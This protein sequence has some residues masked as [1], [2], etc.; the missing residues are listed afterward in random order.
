MLI[1]NLGD[2]MEKEYNLLD[3]FFSYREEEFLEEID[4]DIKSLK[5]RLKCVDKKE[6]KNIIKDIP[7]ENIELKEKLENSIDNLIA[8]YNVL[9]AYYNKKFYKQG[10]NDAIMLNC[11]CNQKR[12]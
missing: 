12:D 8:D 2:V 5:N 7:K 3:R 9:V 6:I 10:F 1:I 11:K 4:D